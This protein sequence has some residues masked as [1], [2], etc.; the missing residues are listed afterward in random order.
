MPAVFGENGEVYWRNA[1]KG[2]G[3]VW[4][5]SE[6]RRKKVK[7]IEKDIEK[8]KKMN[9]LKTKGKYRCGE[10]TYRSIIIVYRKHGKRKEFII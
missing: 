5:C 4:S 9:S 2:V 6:D 7:I 8:P 3:N 10:N 1:G